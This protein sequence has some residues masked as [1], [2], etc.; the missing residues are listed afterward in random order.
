MSSPFT[1]AVTAPLA[2]RSAGGDIDEA[3]HELRKARG[4]VGQGVFGGLGEDPAQVGNGACIAVV[5]K[6]AGV[7]VKTLG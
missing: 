6:I 3:W 7:Q 5:R 4:E 2:R 1:T